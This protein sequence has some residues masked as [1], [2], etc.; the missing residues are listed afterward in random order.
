MNLM[1]LSKIGIIYKRLL[2]SYFIK[3]G[4]YCLIGRKSSMAGT[5]LDMAHSSA[6]CNIQFVFF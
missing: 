5:G 1:L 2:A 3:E 4:I 6:R